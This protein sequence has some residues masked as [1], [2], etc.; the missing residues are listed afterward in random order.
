MDHMKSVEENLAACEEKRKLDLLVK[1]EVSKL[2]SEVAKRNVQ[3]SKML[4][5]RMQTDLEKKLNQIDE[6]KRKREKMLESLKKERHYHATQI[7]LQKDEL[8][9]EVHNIQVQK[10]W[11]RANNLLRSFES[12][13]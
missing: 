5:S 1:S 11:N 10:S 6:K 2:K 4:E 7:R 8:L 12:T 9:D 13:V 3:R